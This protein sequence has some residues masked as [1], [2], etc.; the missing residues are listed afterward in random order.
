MLS[1]WMPFPVAASD[2][3]NQENIFPTM[4]NTLRF[5]PVSLK[6]VGILPMIPS[7]AEIHV[8]LKSA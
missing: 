5:E 6:M 7:G 3:S 4:L 1:D 8:P 2:T